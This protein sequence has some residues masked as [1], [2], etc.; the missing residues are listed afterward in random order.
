M[1]C[2]CVY[3]PF[4]WERIQEKQLLTLTF[5]S[6]SKP[7][8]CCE[9]TWC[10]RVLYPNALKGPMKQLILPDSF[11]PFCWSIFGKNMTF[12]ILY[13]DVLKHMRLWPLVVLEKKPT[14]EICPPPPQRV[15]GWCTGTQK[16]GS[17]CILAFILPAQ[18]QTISPEDKDRHHMSNLFHPEPGDAE[19]N[20]RIVEVWK[21]LKWTEEE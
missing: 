3:D 5:G 13:H 4:W 2:T 15:F 20:S 7:D 16:H 1:L 6:I 14:G 11:I 17:L 12:P 9:K 10:F 19:Y 21:G 8:P 18:P